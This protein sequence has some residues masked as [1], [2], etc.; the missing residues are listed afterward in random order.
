MVTSRTG[1]YSVTRKIGSL[2]FVSGQLP[3]VPETQVLPDSFEQQVEQ[4]LR[5]LGSVLRG[6][7]LDL[8]DVVRTTVY[9]T[10]L[11]L[12]E[13]MNRIYARFFKEP[14][15]ARTCIEVTGLPKGAQVELDAI[16]GR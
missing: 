11:Q 4:A 10:D 14:Y 5:N 1:P 8:S 16:A 6:N 9:M 2:V 3:L 13:T 7:G 15:P 12:F